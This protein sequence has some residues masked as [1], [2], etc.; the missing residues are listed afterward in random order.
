VPHR[1]R[2]EHD[3][4]HPV[5]VTLRAHSH[6]P[7]FRSEAVRRLVIG[8]L[9]PGRRH[10]L[11]DLRVIHFSIQSDHVHLIVEGGDR[12]RLSAG[13]RSFVIR[14]ALRLNRLLGRIKGKVWA[15]RYHR[16][17]LKTPTETR[18]ALAYVLANY[19]KHGVVDRDVPALDPFSTAWQFDG[20]TLPPLRVIETVRWPPRR[21]R[22]WLLVRGWRRAGPPIAP[23]FAPAA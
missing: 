15:D 23:S 10:T 22:T 1:T 7:S 21:A 3:E 17:D 5:H 16:H 2:P 11:D 12:H 8:L 14:F 19:K 9:A 13:L 4:R 20:W 18:N 6:L